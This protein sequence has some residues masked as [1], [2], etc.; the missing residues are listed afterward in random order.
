MNAAA[1]LSIAGCRIHLKFV[2][3]SGVYRAISLSESI[4][5]VSL[6]AAVMHDR[7]RHRDFLDE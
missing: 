4:S 7:I 1:G 5:C 2:V 6:F 3:Q